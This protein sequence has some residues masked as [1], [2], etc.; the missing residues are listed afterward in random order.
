MRRYSCALSSSATS[1]TPVSSV[2]L[3]DEHRE[4]AGD[5]V[6]P[7]VALAKSIALD[8]LDIAQPRVS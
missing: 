3:D 8:G 2:S 5:A 7:Q 1:G 4:V 6:L